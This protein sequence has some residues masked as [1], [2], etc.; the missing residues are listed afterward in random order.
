MLCKEEKGE[1]FAAIYYGES[2]FSGYTRTL[3]HKEGIQKKKEDNGFAKH[4][5]ECHPAREGDTEAFKFTVERTF[6]KPMER[7]VSEAVGIHTC[8]ANLVLN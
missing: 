4:L 7:Q 6:R 3:E 1:E 8:Q 5:A 2:G